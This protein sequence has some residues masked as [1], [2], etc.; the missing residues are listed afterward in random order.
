M[1]DHFH[2]PQALITKYLMETIL[3]FFKLSITKHI[4]ENT[5]L[6]IKTIKN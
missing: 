3:L 6:I 1:V 4:S 5:Y 2:L